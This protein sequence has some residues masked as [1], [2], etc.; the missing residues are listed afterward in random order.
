M[1]KTPW[2]KEEPV[3]QETREVV[4]CHL[5]DMLYWPHSVKSS[6]HSERGMVRQEEAED[7][8]SISIF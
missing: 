6:E 2:E 3:V 4:K 1:P 5:G 7:S 8:A